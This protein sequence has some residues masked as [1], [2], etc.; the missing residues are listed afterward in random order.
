VVAPPTVAPVADPYATVSAAG[1]PVAG[2]VP[3]GEM[4]GAVPIAAPG[5]FPQ[6]GM[7]SGAPINPAGGGEVD[8]VSM[9]LAIVSFLIVIGMVVVL[10]M[11]KVE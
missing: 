11:M 9:I 6:G 4:P 2:P 8:K 5:S 7:V 1:A 3:A 10:A